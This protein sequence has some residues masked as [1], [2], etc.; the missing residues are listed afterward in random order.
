VTEATRKKLESMDE[1]LDVRVHVYDK[2]DST[3]LRAK[4]YIK[5]LIKNENVDE[6]RDVF[7]ADQQTAG[8]GRLGRNWQSPPDTGIWMSIVTNPKVSPDKVSCITLLAAMS[9]T[10]TIKFY[11][12]KR[13]IFNVDI[14]IKWPN[15][16]IINGKKICGILSEL[17]HD[18]ETG[19]N[20]VICGIGINVNTRSFD[21][22]GCE[23]ASSL[24]RESG[25]Q[26]VREEL[27]YGV[28]YNFKKYLKCFERDGSLEFMIEEYNN[29]LINKDQEVILSSDNP[30]IQASLEER[31]IARGIDNT[32]ALLVEDK[33]GE[34][35]SI[36]SGE[37]SVRGLYGYT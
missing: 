26:W 22:E 37:V 36:T 21:I 27:I 6:V 14:K 17:L 20:Y 33:S 13:S 35:R 9:I 8:R 3:N 2:T 23:Y 7:V 31:Y 18:P 24:Y 34:V 28:I 29:S 30:E 1:F 5:E 16:L 12:L 10:K 25:I 11:C 4:D 19:I 15:D 32:G